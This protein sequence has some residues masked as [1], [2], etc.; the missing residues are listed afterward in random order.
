MGAANASRG[1][2]GAS[3]GGLRR[4]RGCGDGSADAAARGAR[5]YRPLY[6]RV[7]GR[8]CATIGA[9]PIAS[10][11]GP[12]DPLGATILRWWD[13]SRPGSSASFA[14]IA[15]FMDEH[16]D[17]PDQRLLQINA[18]VAMARGVA[19][20]DVIAWYHWRDPISS[21]GRLRYADALLAR[22]EGGTRS[23]PGSHGVGGGVVHFAGASRDPSPLSLDAA[24]RRSRRP[25]GSPCVG[26][27][28]SRGAAHVPLCRRGASAAGGGAAHAPRAP[29]RRGPGDRAGAGGAARS[30]GACLRAVALAAR[31]GPRRRRPRAP[32][33]A[34][35]G[36][37]PAAQALVAGT[38]HPGA[39]RPSKTG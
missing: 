6:G 22:G 39:T 18:E 21:H 27:S 10:P 20:A 32:A 28:C 5:R 1:G 13:Y 7:Q 38:R 31:E 9:M 36:S 25:A 8:R 12:S 24:A 16:P 19:D 33:N 3:S 35:A 15:R 17:W 4:S 37:R 34:A 23:S 11:G 29:G 26:Q 14:E 2:R 30:S